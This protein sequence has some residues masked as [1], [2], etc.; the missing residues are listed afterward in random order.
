MPCSVHIISSHLSSGHVGE[1]ADGYLG[2]HGG[3]GYGSRNREGVSILEFAMANNM[4]VTN[5]HFTKTSNHLITYHS[6]DDNTQVDY[7]L[8]KK[9]HLSMVKDVKVI[10]G[11]ECI[12]QHN[13]LVCS[14]K[15]HQSETPQRAYIPKRRIWKLKDPIVCQTYEEEFAKIAHSKTSTHT[16]PETIWDRLK[17]SLLETSDKV[18][19]WTRKRPWRKETWWWD[20][21]VSAAVKEK[22]IKWKEWKKGGSKQK[23]LEA[24]RTAKRAVYLSKKKVDTAKFANVEKN[25]FKIAKHMKGLNREV[26]GEKCVLNDS[27][28]IATSDAELKSAWREHYNRLL[29]QEN[30][31]DKQHLPPSLPIAGPPVCVTVDMVYLSLAKTK[32]GKAAAPSETTS[33]MIKASGPVGAQ[34]IGDL[35]NSIIWAGRIPKDWEESF[36]I[37]LL[38]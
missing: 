21:A 14:L 26:V 4:V 31:W 22:K 7:I 25:I 38:S 9:Q 13:L 10:P 32:D 28:K 29:N 27:G 18:C 36:I 17:T 15:L 6:G 1:R 30:D 3:K 8:T 35:A 33:E 37:S 16:D 34:L 11:E 5:T 19:G 24:K 20:D 2:I 12:P 23:Y